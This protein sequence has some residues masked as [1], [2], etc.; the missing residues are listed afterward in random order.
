MDR[1]TLRESSEDDRIVLSP[2]N[3]ADDGAQSKGLVKVRQ[4]PARR[5]AHYPTL[6]G[7]T[8]K[9]R[10]T[11]ESESFGFL[12]RVKADCAGGAA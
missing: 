3:S 5:Y 10:L 11:V 4:A 9:S 2:L 12:R 7:F 6:R 1:A 8:E